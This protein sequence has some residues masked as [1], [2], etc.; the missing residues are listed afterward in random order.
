MINDLKL[1]AR[2]HDTNEP[3][4]VGVFFRVRHAKYFDSRSNYITS[5]KFVKLKRRSCKGCIQ[6]SWLSDDLSER[7]NKDAVIIPD[8]PDGTIVKL[9][10]TNWSKDWESGYYDDWDLIFEPVDE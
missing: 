5:T 7:C 8:V 9:G 6:C 3:T 2:E 10:A 1:L 4:C